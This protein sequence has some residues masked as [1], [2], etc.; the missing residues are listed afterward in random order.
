MSLHQSP[1]FIGTVTGN[2]APLAGASVQITH[3]PSGTTSNATSNANGVFSASGL[4]VGGPYTVRVTAEG[5][6]DFE[7]TDVYTVV[8]QSFALPVDMQSAGDTIIVTASK[9]RGAGNVSARP[10]RPLQAIVR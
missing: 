10:A 6:G 2:G 7:A 4:R 3:V 9:I 8:G 5:F 1:C